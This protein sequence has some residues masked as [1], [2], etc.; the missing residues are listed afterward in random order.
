MGAVFLGRG[1]TFAELARSPVRLG[2]VPPGNAKTDSTLRAEPERV[3]WNRFRFERAEPQGQPGR[4]QSAGVRSSVSGSQG[5][6][7]VPSIRSDAFAG[8]GV[9]GLESVDGQFSPIG[10][11]V[12]PICSLASF[13]GSKSR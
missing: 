12:M 8:V 5:F 4:C 1:G 9:S 6:S 10:T 11:I 3:E 7:P 13:A 2:A